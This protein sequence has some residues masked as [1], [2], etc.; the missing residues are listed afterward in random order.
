MGEFVTPEPIEPLADPPKVFTQEFLESS[1]K[2][3][4]DNNEMT[5]DHRLAF[6]GITDEHGIKGIASLRLNWR[7]DQLYMRIDALA[8]HEWTGD[9]KI[10]AQ[11]LFAVK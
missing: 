7:G 11:L 5:K 8:E 6:V 10:G 2:K 1:V 9:N 4:I 3:F